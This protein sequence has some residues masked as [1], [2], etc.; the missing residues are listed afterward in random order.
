MLLYFVDL[1]KAFDTLIFDILLHKLQ[2]YGVN[3]VPLLLIKSNLNEGYQ[4]TKYDV[5]PQGSILGPL[6]FGIY[7]NDL[8][9]SSNMFNFSMYADDT[10][11]YFNLE[12]FIFQNRSM[13]I[14]MN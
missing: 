9:N 11:L 4:Y 8:I 10:T 14:I 2:Y 6:F 13:L 3:G 1:S 5:I 12:Y 7:I